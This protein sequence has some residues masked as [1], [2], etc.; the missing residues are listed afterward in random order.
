MKNLFKENKITKRYSAVKK[1][2]NENT[3][4]WERTFKNGILQADKDV[5]LQ[6]FKDPAAAHEYIEKLLSRS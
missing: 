6:E 1:L 2:N 5:K 4:V 3:E